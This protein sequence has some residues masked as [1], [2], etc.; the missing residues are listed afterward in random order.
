MVC[1]EFMG[2]RFV[3]ERGPVEEYEEK[4]WPVVA[5][6]LYLFDLMVFGIMPWVLLL[7]EKGRGKQKTG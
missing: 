3:R 1:V 5:R 2:S 4:E 6:V 7:M